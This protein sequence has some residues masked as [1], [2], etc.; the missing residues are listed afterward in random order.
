MLYEWGY[1]SFPLLAR[2]TKTIQDTPNIISRYLFLWNAVLPSIKLL[3]GTWTF[4]F[5]TRTKITVWFSGNF[6]VK[7]CGCMYTYVCFLRAG[8]TVHTYA[9]HKPADFSDFGGYLTYIGP[10]VPN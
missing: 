6:I 5:F 2:V 8:H 1:A 3:L 10:N 4:I 7:W 9:V